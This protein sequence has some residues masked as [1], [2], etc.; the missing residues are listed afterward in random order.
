MNNPLYE[1]SLSSF[2]KTQ[3]RTQ[4][5]S[6]DVRYNFKPNLYVTAQ[7]T[8]STSKGTSD[9]FKSPDSNFFG[10]STPLNQKGSY[11]LGN[12]GTDNWSAKVV[13]NWI[14]N[15]DNDGTMFTLNLGWEA[16]RNKTTSSYLTGS[17]FLSDDLA[18]ISYATTYS[19]GSASFRRRGP[20]HK[21]RWI[22]RSQLHSQE[23]LRDRR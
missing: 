23:P 13:G 17:G 2:S 14:H 9:V 11:T 6:L 3:T 8:Y 16:K 5:V 4:N 20:L 19:T 15:F 21:R 18:D 12:L 10:G 1:A 22:C 7:G